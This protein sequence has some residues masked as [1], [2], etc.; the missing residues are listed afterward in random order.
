[1]FTSLWRDPH[2]LARTHH[3]RPSIGTIDSTSLQVDSSFNPL[4]GSVADPGLKALAETMHSQWERIAL[5]E[6]ER[7]LTR[8]FVTMRQPLYLPSSPPSSPGAR[9]SPSSSPG[10]LGSPGAEEAP[11]RLV[12]VLDAFSGRVL[13][14]TG[15]CAV[16]EAG[17]KLD[18]KII[19]IDGHPVI[20]D[21]I[22]P[23]TDAR[24]SKSLGEQTGDVQMLRLTVAYHDTEVRGD[25]LVVKMRVSCSAARSR[26]LMA[27]Q[28]FRLQEGGVSKAEPEDEGEGD[29][30]GE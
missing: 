14:V 10:S 21:I 22:S 25:M 20:Q 11:T 26:S 13:A 2:L 5:E 19:S 27:P 6:E 18:F 24:L 3:W 28:G 12:G 29:D 17:L 8:G 7:G 1:M 30:E 23:L 9:S 15:D 16:F 4:P